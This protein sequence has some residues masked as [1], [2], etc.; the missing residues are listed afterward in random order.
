MIPLEI[1]PRNFLAYRNPGPLNLEGIHVACLA[2]PNGA[3]KT[4]L[5]DA[6][7]WALWGKARSNSPDDLF[8]QLHDGSS[9]ADSGDMSV[10][11]VFKQD[12]TRY[13][14][15]RQRTRS[16]RASSLLEFQVWN[17]ESAKWKQI[18]DRTMRGTQERI[19]ALL[20]LDYDTFINSAFLMQGRADEFTTKTPAQRKQVLSNILGLSRWEDY[21]ER[22][23]SRVSGI[24]ADLQRLDG[25]L[26]EIDRELSQKE[27][28]TE[29]LER[30]EESAVKA[31]ESLQNLEREWSDLEQVRTELVGLQRQIDDSTRRITNL[32]LEISEAET[33]KESLS[34][35]ANHAALLAAIE[36]TRSELKRLELLVKDLA[37]F[38]KQR[39]QMGEEVAQRTGV[40]QALGPETEP[41]KSRVEILKAATEPICPTC[42]QRLTEAHRDEL[43]AELEVDIERR[44]E[45]YRENRE[46]IK[47]LEIAMAELDGD[48]RG[49]EAEVAGRPVM[50]K[51]IGELEAAVKHADEAA[52]RIRNL[53]AK[54]RRWNEE[55]E[56][57]SKARARLEKSIE[58]SEKQ[59]KNASVT[60]EVLDRNR[61]EKRMADE[62]VGGARQQMAA[63]E[64]LEV[65]RAQRVEERDRL[66]ADL[67][68]YEELREAFGKRGVPAMIIEAAVPELERTATDFLRRL[69]DGRM[70]L[71]IETQR[72]IKTGEVR[73][74]LDI[75]IS[76]ELGSRP[77]EMYSGGEAFRINFSIRI[78]LSRLL[79][80]R[81][82]ARL[83]SL[84]IDEGF[85]TQ[86]TQGR[87]N[88]VSVINSIQDDF[89]LIL[90]ITHIDELK[91]AFPAR[92]EVRKTPDGSRY[93]IT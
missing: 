35:S 15:L 8:Y 32:Q 57:A 88:L 14:V 12:S 48:I 84:F 80:Q 69:T 46:R 91:D 64:A 72:E 55:I 47:E 78:A 77:Y 13:R 18:S 82:G 56:E 6:M 76:D 5:L 27:Q 17:P 39:A 61:R 36:E 58:K 50:E 67:G 90:V 60:Q 81:A 1:E 68:L 9:A 45:T 10:S 52:S 22:A 41:I 16:K 31:A 74:A 89:D 54:I 33:E 42:G 20:R 24:R 25:R 38:T 28:R 37:G 63:L 40:N 30:A 71:R 11:V 65:Q 7:T 34:A 29:E 86:D 59:L 53:D 44:R 4:S 73:E 79:A 87:E 49:L 21:E 26:E 70:N 85:G 83:R 62:R 92:I 3:G 93:E 51:R 23:K 43:L 2:G 66:A 75:I 19:E